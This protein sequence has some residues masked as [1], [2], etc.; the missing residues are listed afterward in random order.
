MLRAIAGSI[1]LGACIV[2][3]TGGIF[4]ACELAKVY[5]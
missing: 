2:Y 5:Y 1:A 4:T 3:I